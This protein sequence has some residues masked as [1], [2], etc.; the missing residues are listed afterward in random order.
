LDSEVAKINAL[1]SP[2]TSNASQL[3]SNGDIL[4]LQ[5][6]LDIDKLKRVALQSLTESHTSR[7]SSLMMI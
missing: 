1:Q 6:K 5:A 4:A 2:T 3:K 7:I